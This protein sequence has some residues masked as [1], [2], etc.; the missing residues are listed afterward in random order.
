MKKQ[1]IIIVVVMVLMVV[2]GVILFS[3]SK[4]TNLN[5]TKDL[6][7]MMN[8][9]KKNGE[10]PELETKKIDYKDQEQV[11]SY[12][13]LTSNENIEGLVVSEPMIGSQAYSAVAIKV[14]NGANIENMKQEII[15][16]IDMSKWICVT[17]EK[18]YITNSDQIIFFVMSDEEWATI[19]YQA[20]KNYVNN[21]IGKELEKTESDIEL[22]DEMIVE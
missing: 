18:L 6:V 19:T 3:N 21:K 15:D 7:S 22:P 1:T 12:T 8:S 16:H 17:A 9:I 14:K 10:L 20:F 4:S 5:T 11:T 2:L 13:G